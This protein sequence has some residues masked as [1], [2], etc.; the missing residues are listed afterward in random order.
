[1]LVQGTDTGGQDLKRDITSLFTLF[2]FPAEK[3]LEATFQGK[4]L[5]TRV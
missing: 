5:F 2:F 1:M 4:T 3:H